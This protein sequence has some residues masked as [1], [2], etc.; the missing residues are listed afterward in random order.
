[1]TVP[2]DPDR[3][4]PQPSADTGPLDPVSRFDDPSLRY[5]FSEGPAYGQPSGP[6][7]SS[8]RLWPWILSVMLIAAAI[9]VMLAIISTR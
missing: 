1:M 6:A 8:R 2:Q 4:P 5:R 7:R 9:A 3:L